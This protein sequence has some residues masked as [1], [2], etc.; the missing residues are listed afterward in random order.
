MYIKM[1]LRNTVTNNYRNLFLLPLTASAIGAILALCSCS[2]SAPA[3]K[4]KP[5]RVFGVALSQL[6]PEPVYSRLAWV[7]PP[8]PILK[9]DDQANDNSAPNILPVMTLKLKNTALEEV[10]R[11]IASSLNYSSFCSSSIATQKL[12]ITALGNFE[13]LAKQVGQMANANVVIDH[14]NRALRFLA[15]EAP[16][17]VLPEQQ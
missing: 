6:P 12:S 2:S 1:R 13:D 9:T 15:K 11:I 17:A 4:T 14:Q 5:D 8:S 10:A 7:M 3:K 16:Q